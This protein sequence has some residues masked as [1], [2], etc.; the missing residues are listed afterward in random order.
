MDFR[1]NEDQQAIRDAVARICTRY[2]DAYWLARDR[3]GV[4]PEDFVADIAQGGFLGVAMPEAYGGAGLGVTEAAIV[5]QTIARSG[6]CLSGASAIHMNLFGPMPL[7][8][9]G[10]DEQKSRNLPPLIAGRERCCFGVTEPDAGLNTTAISTKAEWDG[11]AYVVHGRKMWTSTAQTAH[12]IMLL[13]RT[14]P[15]D[16]CAKPT[17]GL[18]LFYTDLDR[19]GA[20]EVRE[21]EKMGRKAVDSNAVFFDGLRVPKEDLIGEE[22]KGFHYLLHGLNPERVLIASEA[23]GVG[24]IALEK[25]TDYAREREVFGRPIGQNQAIQHPLARNWAELE[26]ADLMVWKAAALYD[27]GLPCGAEANAAKFLAAEAGF[28]ACEQAVMTHGGMGYAKE[29]H[30]ERYLREVMIAR[31]APVSRELILSFIAE[32]VLG[33]AKSY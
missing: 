7:V 21:I 29:Y 9:F 25:A 24:R 32:K 33:L 14:T 4:F 26:A 10:T 6:A 2:D 18:S 1:F 19:G 30:V 13:A 28:R 27:A 3:D 22:G 15:T 8:V 16:K 31:I 20:T 5:A 12:K 17:E 11:K 23:I